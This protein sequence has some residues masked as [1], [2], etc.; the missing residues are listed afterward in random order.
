MIFKKNNKIISWIF[1]LIF[2]AIAVLFFASYR[3]A[4]NTLSNTEV[5]NPVIGA[6]KQSDIVVEEKIISPQ[7]KSSLG[8]Q[9]GPV[10]ENKSLQNQ[11]VQKPDED[12]INVVFTVGNGGSTLLTTGK[13]DIS[14]PKGAT[15]YDAMTK[16]ASSTSF[17]FSARYYSGLGYFIDAI[18]GIKNA[19]GNYWTLY[20]NGAYATVGASMYQLSTNDSVEWKYTNK[21]NY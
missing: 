7:T 10:A 3:N 14:I 6:G 17:S 18:N 1:A 4:E 12:L 11:T 8:S 19:N 15:V 9:P 16:L 2:V 13:Y 5:P 21:P 20:V